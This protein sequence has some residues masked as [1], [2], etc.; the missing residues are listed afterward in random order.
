MKVK[1]LAAQSCLTLNTTGTV[2]C[3]APLSMEFSRQKYWSGLPFSS[4]GAL[5][6]PGI[7]SRSPALQ[8]DYLLSELREA[9]RVE[10]KFLGLLK[11]NIDIITLLL[12]QIQG[13]TAKMVKGLVIWGI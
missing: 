9:G 13:V 10:A 7:K 11:K 12:M 1:A 4:P 8:A 5:L 6:D 2:A 3:Q